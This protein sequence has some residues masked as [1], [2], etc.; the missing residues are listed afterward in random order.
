[1][2]Y[3]MPTSLA[4]SS[5]DPEPVPFGSSAGTVL[6]APQTPSQPPTPPTGSRCASSDTRLH[7]LGALRMRIWNDRFNYDAFADQY[8]GTS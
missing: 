8:L 1:M 2:K 4:N 5:F 7:H 6:I 3:T